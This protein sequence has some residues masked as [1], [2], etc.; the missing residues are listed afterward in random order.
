VTRQL[1]AAL[2]TAVTV[3]LHTHPTDELL[4]AWDRLVSST[5]GTDVT[6]LSVWARVRSLERFHPSYLFVR[7]DGCLI[8]GAQVLLRG[9]RG[10]GSIGYTSYGPLLTVQG[11]ERAEAAE[12]VALGLARLPG[13]RMLF[14]QPAEGTDDL[15][16]AL[17]RHGFRPSAAGIAPAGSVRLDLDRSLDDIRRAFPPRL[18]S[19]TRRWADAGVTVRIGDES[20][21]PTLTRLQRAAAEARGYARPPHPEYVRHMVSELLRTGNAALFVGEVDGTPVTADVVTTCGTTVRGRLSGFDRK[22]PGGRLSVPGAAR[23]EIIR[24]AKASGYRWLDFGGLT[25]QTLR[26]AVDLGLRR[27][28]AWP[29]ADQAKMQYGGVAFRYPGPVELIRPR[30]LRAAYD[31]ATGSDL[32]RARLRQAQI[33]LRSRSTG[34]GK[35]HEDGSTT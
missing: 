22:G 6:Q 4:S 26:D 25:E 21:V 2:R 10:L 3:H 12:A 16:L 18:R 29:G 7:R 1:T 20:D 19:W 35:S 30:P 13:V 28:D 17:L 33:L 23:W 31:L 24:W 14:V 34:R 15:R 9:V 5:G 32:G 27:S 8:G 11:E